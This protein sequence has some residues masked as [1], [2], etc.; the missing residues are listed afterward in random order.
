MFNR[1]AITA[2]LAGILA[3]AA[4][5]TQAQ[6]VGQPL[7]TTEPEPATGN[8]QG[9]SD[10]PNEMMRWMAFEGAT[11]VTLP[12]TREVLIRELTGAIDLGYFIHNERTYPRGSGLETIHSYRITPKGR[13][14]GHALNLGDDGAVFLTTVGASLSTASEEGSSDLNMAARGYLRPVGPFDG[15]LERWEFT[16]YGAMMLRSGQ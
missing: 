1:R 7:P 10:D 13:A 9:V 3:L 5:P 8:A 16:P 15:E 2:G 6:Q 14:V 12:A 4:A 11:V